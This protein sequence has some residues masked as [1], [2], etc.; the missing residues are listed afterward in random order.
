MKYSLLKKIISF[1]FLF[2]VLI[3]PLFFIFAADGASDLPSGASIENPLKGGINSVYDLVEFIVNNIILPFG[4][5]I[6]VLMII[7]AG[8]QFV[9]AQG[10]PKKIEDAKTTLLYAVIGSAILLGSWAIAEIIQNTV[11][12]ITG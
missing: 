9:V 1:L 7:F 10:N 5:V 8:F 6:M 3:I 4:S 11:T 2:F 12:S